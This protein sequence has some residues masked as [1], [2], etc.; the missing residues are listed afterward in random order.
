M[1]QCYDSEPSVKAKIDTAVMLKN[2]AM[3]ESARLRSDLDE[4]VGLLRVFSGPCALVLDVG[5]IDSRPTCGL[6][7][8]TISV[9][10]EG[11]E[12][13]HCE[14]CHVLEARAFLSRLDRIEGGK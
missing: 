7:E 13:G 2:A 14:D 12:S 6:C 9:N 5:G 11:D 10:A 4:A 1:K 3:K 8:E